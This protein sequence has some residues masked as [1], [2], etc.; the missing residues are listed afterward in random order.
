MNAVRTAALLAAF[1]I[2][3]LAGQEPVRE[4]APPAELKIADIIDRANRS[5]AALV[6]RMRMYHP[7]V[8]VYIQNLVAG[9]AGGVGAEPRR[10]FPR[11]V[12]AGR[13]AEAAA[14]RAVPARRRA[15]S[16]GSPAAATASSFCPTASRAMAAPDW[17][18][19]ERSRYEFKFV[20]R[21]FLGDA[22]CFV[23]DVSP[24]RDRRDGFSGRIW[25]ED[26]DYSIIR[27]NGI[28][29][30]RR[31]D[32]V[33]LLPAHAVVPRGRL[34]RQRD[35]RRLAAVAT[36]TARRPTCATRGRPATAARFKSQVRIWGYE[37][38]AAEQTRSS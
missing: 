34:A 27:F 7:L 25:I 14:A 24:T 18:L 31:P 32:A 22:R 15:W 2:V 37:T 5:E 21:E 28:N 38:Q 4:G 1:A 30:E 6:V 11:P 17:H 16:R 10:V 20:R 23:F 33:E 9:R 26:R 19:L 12:R 29:R 35:A 8:E 36:S 3:P 13:R